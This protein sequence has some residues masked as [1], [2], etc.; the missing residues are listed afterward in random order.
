MP[1]EK[2]CKPLAEAAED[3]V[4]ALL[5]KPTRSSTHLS[6]DVDGEARLSVQ[7]RMGMAT[8]EAAAVTTRVQKRYA[9]QPG[10]MCRCVCGSEV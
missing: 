5:R 7:E 4:L 8:A 3:T 2:G 10:D 9:I 6:L 1:A